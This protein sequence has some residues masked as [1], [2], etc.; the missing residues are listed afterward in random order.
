M[1]IFDMRCDRCAR[2]I[3]GPSRPFEPGSHRGVRF[4]YHPGD[5]SF[6][7]NS[8]LVCVPCWKEIDAWLGADP[9]TTTCAVCGEQ[10]E[11]SLHVQAGDAE[12]LL[13]VT[14]AVEFLN[15]LLTVEPKLD[16]TT[17]VLPTST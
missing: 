15:T 11:S 16:P 17:F 9:S 1:T 8:P 4:A 6:A 7:D 12:W 14:H 3:T 13:C 10:T 5:E 2:G